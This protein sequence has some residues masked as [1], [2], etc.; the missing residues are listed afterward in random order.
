METLQSP[1]PR[2]S[3]FFKLLGTIAV[4]GGAVWGLSNLM[5]P[6][7]VTPGPKVEPEPEPAKDKPL[8]KV[9]GYTLEEWVTPDAKL[10]DDLPIVVV[11]HEQG[12]TLEHVRKMLA[13][14]NGGKARFI[15]PSGRYF[16]EPGFGFVDPDAKTGV[17]ALRDEGDSLIKLV[18]GLRALRSPQRRVIVVGLGGSTVLALSL[19]LYAGF[20]VRDALGVGGSFEPELVPLLGGDSAIRM[21]AQETSPALDTTIKAFQLASSRGF[22]TQLDTGDF[23]LPLIPSDLQAWLFPLLAKLLAI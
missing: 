22:A 15:A 20:A 3:R 1:P 23:D 5:G 18:V 21:L 6:K 17:A 16:V 14:Y 12:S 10:T 7:P 11:L 4:A 13:D 9:A 2:R 8:V 19:A